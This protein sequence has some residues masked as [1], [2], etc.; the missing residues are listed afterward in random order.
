MHDQL[1]LLALFSLTALGFTQDKPS[2]QVLPAFVQILIN[3]TK[4]QPVW[5]PPASIYQYTYKGKTVYYLSA[6]CCDIPSTLFAENGQVLCSPSG[7]FAGSGDGKCI[8][9]FSARTDEALI[10]QDSRRNRKTI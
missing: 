4:N 8:D 10:W 3:Q 5:T 6:R 9:F 7:G 1:K 2:R